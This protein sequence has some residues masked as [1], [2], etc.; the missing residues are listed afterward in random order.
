[1]NFVLKKNLLDIDIFFM[2]NKKV[3]ERK[4]KKCVFNEIINK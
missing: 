4:F 3:V 1:M 2:Y